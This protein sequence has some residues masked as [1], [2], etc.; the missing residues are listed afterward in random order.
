MREYN[1]FQK[2]LMERK[3]ENF[4]LATLTKTEGSTYRK[5]GAEKLISLS[6]DSVGL[7]SGGCL[8]GEIVQRA[9]NIDAEVST[10]VFDTTK[11]EDRLFGYG[12]GCQGVLTIEYKK[13]SWTEASEHLKS[14]SLAK[15]LNV[16]VIGAGADIDPLR[17]ILMSV[18]WMTSFYSCQ[19]DVVEQRAEQGWQVSI[20]REGE[21]LNLSNPDRSAV[22]LMSHSYSTD[23]EVLSTLTE[24]TP[25]YIGIL[26]PEARKVKML[27]DLEKIYQKSFSASNLASIHGPVGLPGFG[28]GEAAIALSIVT[29]L[30]KIFFADSI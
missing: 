17:D 15:S 27:E 22:L 7:I 11:E 20:L 26:G 23:L 18:G 19:S 13:L 16:F 2:F 4:V 5:A 3:S 28:R 21:G 6:G 12:I 10:S 24:R 9:L 8:E 14:T 29:Q 25:A 30:Q 1:S